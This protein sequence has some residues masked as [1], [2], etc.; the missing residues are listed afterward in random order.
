MEDLLRQIDEY[1]PCVGFSDD[2]TLS[3]SCKG[4][5][6]SDTLLKLKKICVNCLVERRKKQKLKTIMPIKKVQKLS[7]CLKTQHQR[8]KWLKKKV[9][10]KTE[11]NILSQS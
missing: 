8:T 5:V 6:E 9:I 7:K 3:T 11:I 1:V 10:I 4:F 2:S